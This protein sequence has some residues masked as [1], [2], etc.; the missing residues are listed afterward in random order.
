MIHVKQMTGAHGKNGFAQ[1]DITNLR[2]CFG[3]VC[4][5]AHLARFVFNLFRYD[6]KVTRNVR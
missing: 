5:P 4:M 2:A 3:A 6:F 1:C